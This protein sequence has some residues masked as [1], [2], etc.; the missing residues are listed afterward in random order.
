MKLS[1]II[2]Y[3][4][5]YPQV[6][7]TVQSIIEELKGTDFEIITIANQS[8]DKGYDVL[9]SSPYAKIGL[10]KNIKHDD[11]LSH[12][13]AKN[14]GI[15]ASTGE[16]LL[17]ID[18]HCIVEQG[19]IRRMLNT[20]LEGSLHMNVCYMLDPRKLNYK[21][22]EGE[23]GYRF[24]VAPLGLKEPF[25]VP[26]M[27]TC[28]MM[29]ERKLID[30][31]GK[32]HPELGIYGGGENY[33]MYKIATCG[34]KIMVHPGATLYHFADKRG[35]SWNYDDYVR[36]Q[37]IAAYCIGDEE[38]LQ[39]LIDMRCSKPHSNKVRVNQIADDVRK[40]CAEDRKFIASKQKM[41]M[42][43]Y[44]SKFNKH[45]NDIV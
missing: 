34:Y 8:K 31:I 32:W 27:S 35:Y 26:V 15:E 36:N 23:M 44:F 1:V 17:F 18:S 37:F 39:K 14:A 2:P 33:L 28:G 20:R 10:L 9:C 13:Q 38:W 7:F 24:T 42:T 40:V 19:S 16:R 6:C 43:E 22:Y 30:D 21:L 4:N 25:Q 3:V 12:W 5:E 29:V 11:K 45:E 41:T